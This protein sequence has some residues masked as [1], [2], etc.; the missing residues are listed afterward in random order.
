MGACP[1]CGSKTEDYEIHKSTDT[2]LL[3]DAWCTVC[4]DAKVRFK[5]AVIPECYCSQIEGPHRHSYSTD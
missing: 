1:G 3:T 2:R 4:I 5:R